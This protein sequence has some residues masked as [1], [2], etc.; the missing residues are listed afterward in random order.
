MR[1]SIPSIMEKK[2]DNFT[3]TFCVI[4]PIITLKNADER[5]RDFILNLTKSYRLD[6]ACKNRD[7]KFC[8]PA[9]FGGIFVFIDDTIIKRYEINGYLCKGNEQDVKT[10]NELFKHLEEGKEWCFKFADN[11]VLCYKKIKDSQECKWIDNIGLRFIMDT[12]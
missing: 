8:Y 6:E 7:K 2:A 11:E 9:V 10:I 5:A 12:L 4:P 3:F 1:I